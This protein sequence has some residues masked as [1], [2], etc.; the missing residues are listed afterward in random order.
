MALKG[1][2]IIC[3]GEQNSQIAQIISGCSGNDDVS[4]PFEKAAGVKPPQRIGSVE[5]SGFAV[6]ERLKVG[7][8]AGDPTVAVDSVGPRRQN[9]RWTIGLAK[10]GCCVESKVLISAADACGA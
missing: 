4:R 9:N 8:R 5:A 10:Q 1:M 2:S 6:V 7:D 3:I